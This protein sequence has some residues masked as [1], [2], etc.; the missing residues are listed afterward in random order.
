MRGRGER[1]EGRKTE[2]EIALGNGAEKIIPQTK[3]FY[4]KT[5]R[6]GIKL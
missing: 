1:E 2:R 6:C 3:T 5:N 4:S